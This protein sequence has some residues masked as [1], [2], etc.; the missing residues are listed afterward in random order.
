MFGSSDQ[1]Y[2]CPGRLVD[3]REWA[4]I[5]SFIV[6]LSI[7]LSV[8]LEAI[9]SGLNRVVFASKVTPR[10]ESDFGNTSHHTYDA[11]HC[12]SSGRVTPVATPDGTAL[13]WHG[14]AGGIGSSP[15]L[16]WSKRHYDWCRESLHRPRV[17]EV[18]YYGFRYYIPQTG[19]WASRDLIEE[20]GGVNLYGFVG[21]D[22]VGKTDAFGLAEN[23]PGG[24]NIPGSN[25]MG[26]ALGTG[27]SY[28]VDPANSHAEALE[29]LGWDCNS[30]SSS[31][32]CKCDCDTEEAA[33][34]YTYVM[35]GSI[36]DDWDD[37]PA[38]KQEAFMRFANHKD[39]WDTPWGQCDPS[40]VDSHFIRRN[41]PT[42]EGDDDSWDYVP[43]HSD[44]PQT[45][46]PISNPDDYWEKDG[47]VRVLG[48]YCCKKGKE[49]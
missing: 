48:K 34:A 25:C 13:H 31:K 27:G 35:K 38:K 8:F 24:Q 16:H 17:L 37:W 32:D 49:E 2:P 29:K 45:P 41:C 7:R 4:E 43:T 42:P 12:P 11:S 20:R 5:S 46:T 23:F 1:F 30:V 18:R 33:M 22:G 14:Q 10:A 9:V 28:Q 6:A 36:D 26:H 39:F 15:R 47:G 3:R 40:T 21:N 44:D 19:R